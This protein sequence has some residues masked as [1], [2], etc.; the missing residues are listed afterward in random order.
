MSEN[1]LDEILAA[2]D[3]AEAKD[4]RLFVLQDGLRDDGQGPNGGR[5]LGA[6]RRHQGHQ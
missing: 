2:I 5:W 3:A 1:M 4:Q 6:K